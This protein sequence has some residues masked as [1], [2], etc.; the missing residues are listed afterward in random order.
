MKIIENIEKSFN[1]N[2][3]YYL[4]ESNHS[5]VYKL[6]YCG[7]EKK[8]NRIKIYMDVDLQNGVLKY[9]FA[10][11]SNN[12]ID[13]A[14]IRERLLDINSTLTL[15]SLSMRKESNIIEY[16]IDYQ[17]N[18]NQFS[19]KKYNQNIVICIKVYERLQQEGLIL[20]ER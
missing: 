20:N 11:K 10:E 18:G 2:K 5:I 19:F 16:R 13:I 3:I 9:L 1:E 6:L 7:I 12:K 17:L 15:G 4:K 8:E 14:T